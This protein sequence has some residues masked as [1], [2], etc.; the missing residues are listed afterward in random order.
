GVAV[1][2]GNHTITA[3]VTALGWW[4]PSVIMAGITVALFAFWW[5]TLHPYRIRPGGGSSQR[6]WWAFLK[7]DDRDRGANRARVLSWAAILTAGLAVAMLA[8]PPLISW[9][10]RNSG[11]L[12]ALAHAIGFG[13]RPTWSLPALVG[14][15]GAVA[16]V[17]KY[18]QGGLAKWNATVGA[19]KAQGAQKP[20]LPAQLAGWLR[21]QLIPWLA[22]AIVVLGGAVLALL[23]TT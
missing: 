9:L 12:G 4:L 8:V 23:W 19:A 17:A 16:A 5:V 18:V 10:T 13:A 1:P 20:G 2:A 15:I 6:P 14:L 22:S 7:P 3:D 11:P 21:Q